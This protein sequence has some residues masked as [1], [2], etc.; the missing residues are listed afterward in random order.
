[1][2]QWKNH[3][4]LFLWIS[5]RIGHPCDQLIH[6]MILISPSHCKNPIWAKSSSSITSNFNKASFCDI[7][8]F[9]GDIPTLPISPQPSNDL[10]K[11]TVYRH[12]R[13]GHSFDFLMQIREEP[14]YAAR[15]HS[16]GMIF[17]NVCVFQ[18]T[19]AIT[20]GRV[21]GLLTHIWNCSVS[22]T[23]GFIF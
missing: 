19:Q 1:M 2:Y 10:F 20:W 17:C 3:P 15:R 23:K 14:A 18:V 8:K 4:V 21:C 12:Y 16:R 22:R 9:F 5:H 13:H 6:A 11:N 7:L